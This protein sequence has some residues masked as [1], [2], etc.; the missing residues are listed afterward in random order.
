MKVVEEIISGYILLKDCKALERIRDDRR[1][2]LSEMRALS[3][4]LQ[5]D[6]DLIDAAMV[7]FETPVG[8]QELSEI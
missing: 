7:C 4:G 8:D 2:L 3:D 5:Q 6:I 1:R